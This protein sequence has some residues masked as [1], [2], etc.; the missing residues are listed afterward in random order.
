MLTALRGLL[1]ALALAGAA[2]SAL[3]ALPGDAWWLRMLDFTR[4]QGLIGTAAVAALLAVLAVAARA[5]RPVRLATGAA[6]I[7]A[8]AACAWHAAVLF[9]YSAAA[10]VQQR[11]A[12]PDCAPA[13]RLR[14]LA[15]NVQMTNQRD[16]RLIRLVRQADP[17]VAW[18]QETDDWWE[19]ELSVLARDM[20]F[21]V[22]HAQPNYFGVHLFSKLPLVDAQVRRL[23]GSRNPSVHAG[24]MLR[25]GRTIGLH[26]IH[27][28]P[29]QMGQGTAERDA[30]LLAT[31]LAARE[32]GGPQLVAGDLNA[33]P[34]ES[35]VRHAQR[36]GGLLDP[37][38]GRGLHITWDA[39]SRVMRWP[40]DQILASPEFTLRSLRVLPA[41]GSDHQP[42]LAEFCLEPDAAAGQPAPALREDDLQAARDAVRKGQDKADGAG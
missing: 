37:R 33:V 25:S 1:V 34:W 21:E 42:L 2:A 16:D 6:A 18:F 35:V 31:A 24:V 29:P 38:A 39:H 10:G 19:R 11:E 12:R 14:L 15:A 5:S 26:A 17:D 7:V 22:A 23:T 27:P 9:P 41:F 30:Q 13:D 8:L 32:A 3:P 28:R 36:V 40:L 20:P 4:L